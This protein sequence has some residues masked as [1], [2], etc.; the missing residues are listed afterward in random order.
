MGHMRRTVAVELLVVGL[1]M[2]VACGRAERAASRRASGELQTA[3]AA[4]PP[5]F[6][7][8]HHDATRIWSTMRAFYASRQYATAWIDGT[9]PRPQLDAL[10]HAI[11]QSDKNGLDPELYDLGPLSETRARA[12]THLIGAADF[13]AALVAPLELRLT[14][15]FLEYA[16]DLANGVTDR[17]D[18]DPM[19]R[20]RPRRIDLRPPLDAVVAGGRVDD[21]LARL[22]PA[23]PEYRRLSEAHARYRAIEAAGGWPKLPEKLALRPGQRSGALAALARRLAIGG[24]MD[25]SV[26]ERPP[27]TYDANLQNGVRRFALRH[28]LRETTR[29]T[30]DVVAAMNVPVAQRIRQI[31]LNMERWRWFPRD[32]GE[33]HIRVNVPEYHLDLWDHG[34]I[35]LAM[36]VIV[37]AIDK[38]TPIFSDQM[39]AII[40]SPYWNVPATIA[41]DETLPGLMGDPEYLARNNLEVVSTSGE[42]VDPATIDWSQADPGNPE[43]FPYRFR[44]KPGTTNSLGLVKFLFPNDFDVYLHD[45]PSAELFKRDFR[46][47]SHGC[48]RIQQPVALAEYLLKDLPSWNA[49]RIE[50][51]MHAGLEETMKLPHPIPVHLMYWTVRVDERGTVQFFDDIYGHDSRQ[52]EVYQARIARMKQKK[53]AVPR[54][55]D[56]WLKR[57]PAR[58]QLSKR[59]R[60]RAQP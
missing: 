47:L 40:F 32:L 16:S 48:V 15:A 14:A 46:A 57:A 29:L 24:D 10:L 35:A 26:A 1:L 45:T 28:G 17:P 11:N 20:V 13:D 23:A 53:A 25:P 33:T 6:V 31:E 18:R 56:E 38:P 34:K 42:V 54:D 12:Q 27:A 37:G 9:K 59:P 3:L 52:W 41:A 55:A 51:A 60:P 36:N 19:W 43:T 5:A 22:G 30:P 50:K 4:S 58:P 44:Q 8:A 39:T 2:A 21:I 7:A 49:P